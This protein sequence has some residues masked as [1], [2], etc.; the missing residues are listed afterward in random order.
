MV[1]AIESAWGPVAEA[2]EASEVDGGHSYC[3]GGR[4][5]GYD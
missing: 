3:M 4:A 1:Q 2:L 5:W